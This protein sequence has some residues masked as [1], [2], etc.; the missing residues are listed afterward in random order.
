MVWVPQIYHT[1]RLNAKN[2]TPSVSFV[3]ALSVSQMYLPLYMN[4][5]PDNFFDKQT[6]FI[7]AFLAALI[8]GAQFSLI[9]F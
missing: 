5:C 3:A 2:H 8:F 1:Y 4:S 7:Y 9:H 6:S